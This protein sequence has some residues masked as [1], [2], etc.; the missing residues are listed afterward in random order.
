MNA[1]LMKFAGKLVHKIVFQFKK[2]KNRA[3]WSPH[4]CTQALS[5]A[6]QALIA[7]QM[8]SIGIYVWMQR[9]WPLVLKNG[10]M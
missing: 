5:L 9:V 3:K 6:V 7:V 4:Y 8:V 1:N 10:T 2:K